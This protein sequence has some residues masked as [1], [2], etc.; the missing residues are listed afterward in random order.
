MDNGKYAQGKRET[1]E[2]AFYVS[3]FEGKMIC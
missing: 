3:G 2:E 1:P